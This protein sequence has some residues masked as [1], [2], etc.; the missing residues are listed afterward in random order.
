MENK[1][2]TMKDTVFK[3]NFHSSTL[4]TDC[5]NENTRSKLWENSLL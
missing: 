5:R 3:M 4:K 2:S 1:G